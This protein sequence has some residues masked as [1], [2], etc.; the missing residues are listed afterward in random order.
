MKRSRFFY[1]ATL[2]GSLLM[3]VVFLLASSKTARSANAVP[4][5]GDASVATEEGEVSIDTRQIVEFYSR[6]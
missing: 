4:E 2:V 5:T 1:L 6:R 3:A